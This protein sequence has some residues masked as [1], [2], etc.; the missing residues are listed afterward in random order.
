MVHRF[1]VVVVPQI[2]L[3]FLTEK[4]AEGNLIFINSLLFCCLN[5]NDLVAKYLKELLSNIIS[6]ALY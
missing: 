5:S 1:A 2:L 4:L 6:P 3:I